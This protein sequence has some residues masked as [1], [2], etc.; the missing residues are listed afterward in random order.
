MNP[1]LSRLWTV[2][3]IFLVI[4]L[5]L[6]VI[7]AIVPILFVSIPENVWS[8]I[9]TFF[10]PIFYGILIFLVYFAPSFNASARKHKNKDAIFALNLLAGWTFIGWIIATVW[11]YTSNVEK[12]SK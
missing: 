12:E 2:T 8:A 3:K 6:F 9:R 4:V 11:S 7:F 1:I 10:P 5:I